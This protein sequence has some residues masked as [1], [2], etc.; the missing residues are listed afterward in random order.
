MWE[1]FLSHELGNNGESVMVVVVS[2]FFLLCVLCVWQQPFS[3]F[4]CA[5]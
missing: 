4:F 1:G 3:S 5:L 2:C